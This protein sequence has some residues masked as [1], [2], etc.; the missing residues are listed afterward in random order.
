MRSV[1]VVHPDVEEDLLDQLLLGVPYSSL[2]HIPGEDAEPDLDLVEPRGVGRGEVQGQAPA[3]GDPGHHL[4]GLVSAQVVQDDVQM[5]SWV[6]PVE[7]FQEGQEFYVGVSLDATA[8]HYS[9]V[10]RQRSQEAGCAVT[11]VIGG[12]PP[13][14]PRLHR[15]IGLGAVQGLDLGLLI[16]GQNQGVLGGVQ[17]EAQ[18]GGLLALELGILALAAPVLHLVRLEPALVE[19]AMHSGSPQ[20]GGLSQ[21]AHA[22]VAGSI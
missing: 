3:T 2:Q 14:H 9:L 16:D 19:D 10:Y 22:P 12:L 8:L 5:H 1:L 7:G 6:L 15:Q 20:A 17:V 4:L 13:G 11:L 21:A 18:D